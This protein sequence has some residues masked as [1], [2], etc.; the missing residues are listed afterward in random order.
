MEAEKGWENRAHHVA[1][2]AVAVAVAVR[3]FG[4]FWVSLLVREAEEEEEEESTTQ[5]R[6]KRRKKQQRSVRQVGLW[7][8]GSAS[9]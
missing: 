8:L 3:G 5:R 7:P 9:A 1:R 4:C 6:R 2:R